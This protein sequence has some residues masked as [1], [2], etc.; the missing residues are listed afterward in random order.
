MC[1][2][3][4]GVKFHERQYHKLF[5]NKEL[6][7]RTNKISLEKIHVDNISKDAYFNGLRNGAQ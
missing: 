7:V 4:T 6:A 1:T 3:L 5:S 2:D